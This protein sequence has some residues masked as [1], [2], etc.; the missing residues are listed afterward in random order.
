MT[1]D[2]LDDVFIEN[3]SLEALERAFQTLA[4]D[5]LNFSQR[6]SPLFLK[7]Y[8]RFRVAVSPRFFYFPPQGLQ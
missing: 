3:L 1:L 2:V 6:N 7:W 5:Y 4:I 8:R